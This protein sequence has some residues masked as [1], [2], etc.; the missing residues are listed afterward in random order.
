MGFP[1]PNSSKE[2]PSEEYPSGENR[3]RVPQLTK[4]VYALGDHSVNLVLSSTS[5]FYLIFLTE[6]AELRPIL[7][8]LVIWIA[9]AVDA[10]SDPAMGRI[11]DLTRFRGQRRRPYFLIGAVP[12]GLFFALMW[13]GAPVESQA[14]K[15]AYY[16]FVYTLLSLAMTVV[17]VPYLALIPEMARSYDERTSLNTYRAAAAVLGTLTAVGMK[18]LADALGGDATAWFGAGV[19]GGCLVVAPWLPVHRVSF[20]RPEFRRAS[21]MGFVEGARIA[22]RQ[23]SYRILV[24]LYILS[25]I[26]M[27]LVSA[28]F[29]L[30]FRIYIGREED[31]GITMALFLCASV[32]SLPM[33]LRIAKHCEKGAI[34]VVGSVWW[35]LANL[36]IFAIQPDW[37]RWIVFSAAATAAVGFTV[38][39]LM[40]WAMLGDVIDEDELETGERREGIFVGF[41]MFL[42]KLGGATGVLL[43]AAVLEF[44]GYDATVPPEAQTELTVQTIRALTSFG[45]SLFLLLAVLVA[46]RYSLT[47]AAH[48]DILE[49]L[50]KRRNVA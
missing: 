44:I 29:L 9:R 48:T 20:E 30:Y 38:C 41:F 32:L 27:D 33:W 21:N 31:F 34:F 3:D 18:P 35:I 1:I 10:F 5:F 22:V 46:L 17:S 37:P 4:V 15:F 14:A 2:K 6:Y 16:A 26:A 28:M 50:T 8:G 23:R 13:S 25:R 43:V 11:S 49:Q 7:A 36:F 24:S 45:P 47:R 19:V 39:D 42:R 40:P 12:F